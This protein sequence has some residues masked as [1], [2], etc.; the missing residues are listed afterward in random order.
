MILLIKKRISRLPFG[1]AFVLLGLSQIS[2]NIIGMRHILAVAALAIAA[3]LSDVNFSESHEWADV[4]VFLVGMNFFMSFVH[5]I[6]L[7][8]LP[9]T[10]VGAFYFGLAGALVIAR[11]IPF[12]R[13]K[14]RAKEAK[15]LRVASGK[16]AVDS[17]REKRQR[18]YNYFPL[19]TLI[20]LLVLWGVSFSADISITQIILLGGLVAALV[21]ADFNF[22]K[23]RLLAIPINAALTL[24]AFVLYFPISSLGILLPTDISG[25]Y[26]VGFAVV[27]CWFPWW[28]F[29]GYVSKT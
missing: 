10:D 15:S 22:F 20:A 21:M 9:I 16:D 28:S 12:W 18:F 24:A 1:I 7:P 11:W 6:G 25:A 17:P 27:Y 26:C 29:G 19:G 4:C 2:W 13:E 8:L 23:S 3:F 14:E 5:R